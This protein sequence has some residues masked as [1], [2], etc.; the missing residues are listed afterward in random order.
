MISRAPQANVTCTPSTPAPARKRRRPNQDLQERLARCE[1]LLK[2]YAGAGPPP[3]TPSKP[4]DPLTP[5]TMDAATEAPTKATTSPDGETSPTYRSPGM[6]TGKMIKD[7]AGIRFMD[8]YIWASVMDQ[9]QAIKEIVDTEEPDES[10]MADSERTSPEN[11][12][13]LLLGVGEATSNDIQDLQP[14]PVH[15]FRLWQLFLDRVNPL[16]KVVHIPT[17]QPYVMEGAVNIGN[18]P[19][20]YQALLF[21]IYTISAMSLSDGE[22]PQLLGM[23]REEAIQRFTKGMKIALNLFDFMKNYDMAALQALVLYVSTLQGRYDRH[24]TWILSG[25]LLR[26][27]Q[28]MGYHR[29]GEMLK[30]PPFETEMRR[31]IWW[32]VIMQDTK[33]AMISGLNHSL[34][35][36]NWDTKRPSN[37]NDADLYPGLT[38][39]VQERDGPTE[40]AFVLVMTEIGKFMI[41]AASNPGFDAAIMGQSLDYAGGDPEVAAANVEKYRGIMR[42]LDFNLKEM[43]NR[44]VDASAGHVHAAALT[45][46]PLIAAKISEMITPPG[47]EIVTPQDRLM[48]MLV[49]NVEHNADAYNNMEKTGFLWFVKPHFQ[50][51]VFSVL[52]GLLAKNPRGPLTERGWKAVEWA[53]Y[54]HSEL[55]DTTQRLHYKQAQLTLKAW[56]VREQTMAELGFPAPLAQPDY[57]SQ[58]KASVHAHDSRSRCQSSVTPPTFTQHPPPL[59]E[60]DSFLGGY[61]DVSQFQWDDMWNTM[62]VTA[63]PEQALPTNEFGDLSMGNMAEMKNGSR[64]F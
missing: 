7:D 63:T 19:L 37:V 12:S 8:S 46:R 28:K 36:V 39:P 38:E 21:S 45:I 51:E 53:Y 3:G 2:Q 10:S 60:L 22:A 9:L 25:T 18:I 43:E 34:L 33:Y 17:L 23:A 49:N 42:D 31:R 62:P 26:I 16:L 32:Q 57:I 14:D 4:A 20:N 1:D 48:K 44:Y 64:L 30:L 41:V 59:T 58:L 56:R 54:Q 13:D 27:S 5:N 61:I 47:P 55:L 11:N 35:P 15:A 50:L 6:A 40:M 24:A 52:T 29:D